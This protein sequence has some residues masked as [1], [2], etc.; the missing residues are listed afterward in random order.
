MKV[1]DYIVYNFFFIEKDYTIKVLCKGNM[2]SIKL[3]GVCPADNRPSTDYLHHKEKERKR[4]T[5]KELKRR[6]K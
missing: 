6:T 4:K 2:K 3:E 5:I 1:L